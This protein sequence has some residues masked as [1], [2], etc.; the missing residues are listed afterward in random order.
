M[1]QL[2]LHSCQIKHSVTPISARNFHFSP[3]KI[4]PETKFMNRGN[5]FPKFPNFFSFDSMGENKCLFVHF[6]FFFFLFEDTNN[7]GRKKSDSRSFQRRKKVTKIEVKKYRFFPHKFVN[8]LKER[9]N[10]NEMNLN[11][12]SIEIILEE[13]FGSQLV[14][15]E[16]KVTKIE[17]KKHIFLTCVN[18]LEERIVNS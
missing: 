11:L 9:I 3:A 18:F 7:S 4:I 1:R 17:V 16:R 15:R 6:F 14:S 13:I 2:H 5:E 12:F 8:F 10:L